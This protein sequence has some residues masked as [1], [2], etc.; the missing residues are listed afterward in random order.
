MNRLIT[1]LLFILTL[2]I[3]AFAQNRSI[4]LDTMIVT[5]HT[6]TINGA[7]ISY[8]AT[9]GMQPVWDEL[10]KPIAT[11]QYTYYKRNDVGNNETRPY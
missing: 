1:T 5:K 3:A 4:P 10:G 8:T 9:A 6:S 7:K 11:L 2:A